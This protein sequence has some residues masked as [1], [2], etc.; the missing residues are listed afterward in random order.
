[1]GPFRILLLDRWN[2]DH[3]AMSS[4]ASQPAH[5]HTQQHRGVEPVSF[6][7]FGS[8]ETATLEE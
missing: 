8:R 5:E 4:L 1:M 6:R 3:A 7:A 2:R